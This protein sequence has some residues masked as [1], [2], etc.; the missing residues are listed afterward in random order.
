MDGFHITDPVIECF[1]IGEHGMEQ[2]AHVEIPEVIWSGLTAIM[3]NAFCQITF[4]QSAGY[5]LFYIV[6][7]RKPVDIEMAIT[8]RH[9]SENRNIVYCTQRSKPTVIQHTFCTFLLSECSVIYA[10]IIIY[11]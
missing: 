8:I 5:V 3:S 6:S 11:K 7:Q 1:K 10:K 9:I 4:V 2:D